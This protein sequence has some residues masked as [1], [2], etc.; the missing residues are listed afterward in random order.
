[1]RPICLL[2]ILFIAGCATSSFDITSAPLDSRGLNKSFYPAGDKAPAVYVVGVKIKD[3]D[4]LGG[5]DDRLISKLKD[6]GL[7]KSVTRGKASSK[8]QSELNID[9]AL[10]AE[11]D[12]DR[13]IFHNAS[14]SYWS[15]RSLFL[16]APLMSKKKGYNTIQTLRVIWP[17][18]Q[19]SQYTASCSGLARGSFSISSETL[20][21]MVSAVDD[22]CLTSVINQMDVDYSKLITKSE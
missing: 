15:G 10:S 2:P 5:L 20:E 16:L 18:A 11:E 21:Q 19:E 6:T 9:V 3:E 8:A 4:T 14:Q 17:N 7:Y 12:V 1:M 13:Y 22:A